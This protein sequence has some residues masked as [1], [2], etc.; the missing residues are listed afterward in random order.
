MSYG[1]DP[2]EVV[3]RA[4]GYVDRIVRGDNPATLPVQAPTKFD[5]IVNLKTA[6]SLGI[7]ITSALLAQADEVVE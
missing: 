7:T 6:R 2:A 1:P 3:R 4:G 5:F